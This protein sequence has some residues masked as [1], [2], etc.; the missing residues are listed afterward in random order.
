MIYA[1]DLGR[2][3][4]S[5]IRKKDLAGYQQDENFLDIVINSKVHLKNDGYL[6]LVIKT[7]EIFEN[8]SSSGQQKDRYKKIKS[9]FSII[10]EI[11]LAVFFSG[12]TMLIAK[13]SDS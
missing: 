8:Q 12:Q 2:N 4:T 10:Q 5:F 11:N 1:E 6:M 13:N 3:D 9:L 7:D